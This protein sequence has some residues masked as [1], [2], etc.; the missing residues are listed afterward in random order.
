M[1]ANAGTPSAASAAACSRS[2][3]G[4]PSSDRA[5]SATN[6]T[7]ADLIAATRLSISSRMPPSYRSLISTTTV[8]AGLVILDWQYAR[9]R[10][11]SVPPPS[12]VPKSTSTGSSSWSVRSATAVSK[13]T[14]RVS[15]ERMDASTAPNTDA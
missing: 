15:S 4:V 7:P 5:S 10:L 14:S 12:R 8:R 13:T 6:S 2:Y 1:H 3:A 9:A 11:M